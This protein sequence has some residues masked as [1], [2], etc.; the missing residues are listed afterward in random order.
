[1]ARM[2][3]T[4]GSCPACGQDVARTVSTHHGLALEHYTCP[5]HGRMEPAPHHATVRD[6]VVAPTMASLS[7]LLQQPIAAG[8]DWVR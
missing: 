2:T 7:E 3:L 4:T 1:M 6:W 5:E 8:I